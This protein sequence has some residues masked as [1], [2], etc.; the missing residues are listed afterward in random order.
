TAAP[1]IAINVQWEGDYCRI[2]IRDNGCGIPREDWE[3]VFERH[4][5]TKAEGGFGLYYA[6]EELARF[7]GKIFVLDS[8]AGSGTTMRVVLRRS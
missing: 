6:R 4:F 2:D 1:E 3:R 8:A 5:T 7:G